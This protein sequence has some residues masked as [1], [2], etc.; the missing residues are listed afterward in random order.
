MGHDEGCER[1]HDA[2]RLMESFDDQSRWDSAR[3]LPQWGHRHRRRRLR[4]SGIR[5]RCEKPVVHGAGANGTGNEANERAAASGEGGGSDIC[6]HAC[7]A[8]TS[9]R[10]EVKGKS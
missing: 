6:G 9:G 10:P 3:H 1:V 5:Q 4:Q 7:H 8:R 2:S